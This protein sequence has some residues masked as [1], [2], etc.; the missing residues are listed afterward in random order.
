MGDKTPWRVGEWVSAAAARP[1][2]IWSLQCEH[3]PVAHTANTLCC[4]MTDL[5]PAP[6][7]YLRAGW[8]KRGEAVNQQHSG[9]G[10]E[11]AR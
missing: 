10:R 1:L 2:W 7:R 4:C 5:S 9:T 11:A 8:R 6:P 3:N